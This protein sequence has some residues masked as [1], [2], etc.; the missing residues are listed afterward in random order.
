VADMSDSPVSR[1][2][3]AVTSIPWSYLDLQQYQVLGPTPIQRFGILSDSMDTAASYRL[4]DTAPIM[5]TYEEVCV[6]GGG[7][8]LGRKYDGT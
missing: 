8:A 2:F 4:S 3:D 5:M 1:R 7:G 6:R